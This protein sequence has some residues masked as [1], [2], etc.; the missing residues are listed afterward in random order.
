MAKIKNTQ[1]FYA[2]RLSNENM[3]ITKTWDECFNIV[4]G[5]SYAKY[6]KFPT[7]EKAQEWLD[8]GAKYEPVVKLARKNL[9]K[10]IYCD[11]GTGKT[12]QVRVKITDENGVDLCGV[13]PLDHPAPTNNYGELFVF[14]EALK[15][16][17]QNGHTKVFSDSKLILNFWSKGYCKIEDE[18]TLKIIKDVVVLR[19]I[20]EEAGGSVNYVSGDDNPAD[21]GYHR[22]KR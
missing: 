18:Q 21:L 16:A 10:G 1:T 9:D 4:K 17:M 2:W 5:H 3:G 14:R 12:N 6:K 8:G 20:F 13:I 7:L 11:S 19:K 22:P 15:Y